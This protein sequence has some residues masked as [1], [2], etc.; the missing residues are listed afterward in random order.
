MTFDDLTQRFAADGFNNVGDYLGR[1]AIARQLLL[2][3]LDLQHRLPGN[4]FAGNIGAAGNLIE[5]GLDLFSLCREH[6]QVV[7]V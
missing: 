1:H 2:I 4:L 7:A 5:N 3:E 6:V